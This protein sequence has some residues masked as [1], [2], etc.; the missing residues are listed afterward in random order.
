MHGGDPP[1]RELFYGVDDKNLY[2]RVDDGAGVKFGIEFETG[3]AEA[4]VAQGHIIEMCAPRS[5]RRFRLTAARE[6][7]PSATVP[8]EGWIEL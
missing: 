7:L 2:V 5:G 3:P 1:V 4:R 6:G 8:Q